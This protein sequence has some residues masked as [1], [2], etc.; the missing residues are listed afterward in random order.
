MNDRIQDRLQSIPD[1]E[2]QQLIGEL[3]KYLPHYLIPFANFHWDYIIGVIEEALILTIQFEDEE[4][5]EFLELNDPEVY[6]EILEAVLN[7]RLDRSWDAP[8]NI[9]PKQF[10]ANQ[11]YGERIVLMETNQDLEELSQFTEHPSEVLQHRWNIFHIEP[12]FFVGFYITRRRGRLHAQGMWEDSDQ[13]LLF[14]DFAPQNIDKWNRG[15]RN[16][17]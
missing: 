8:Y 12:P 1:T 17:K 9:T 14:K 7:A 11:I 13:Y 10:I 15:T 3:V 4:I 16:G 5:T 2:Y 6:K